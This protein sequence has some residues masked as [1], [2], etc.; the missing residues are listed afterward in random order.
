MPAA[1]NPGAGGRARAVAR[2]SGGGRFAGVSTPWGCVPSVWGVFWW[3]VPPPSA[4]PPPASWQL[5][6]LRP[7]PGE[8]ANAPSEPALGVEEGGLHSAEAMMLARYFM[9]S[10]LYFHPI[11]R[12][13]DIHLKDF[14]KAWLQ[15]GAFAT[16]VDGHLSLT[17]N[18]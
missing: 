2:G 17:D 8:Q 3:P 9:Y 11:R 5:R 16:D 14:L 15:N 1:V 7:T 4:A 10:Q 18:E 12:I 13:Y 6:I